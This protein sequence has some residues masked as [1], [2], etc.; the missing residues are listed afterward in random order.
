MN[1]KLN[2]IVK[3]Y[4]SLA[5]A[6]YFLCLM[7]LLT[8]QACG[9]QLNRNRIQLPEQATS[10]AIAKIENRS[11]VPRL[12]IMLRGLLIDKFNANSIDMKPTG[13]ADLVLTFVINSYN[14]TRDEYALDDTGQTY[15]F[16]FTVTGDLS[17]FDNRSRTYYL[18]GQKI[19]SSHSIITEA[20]DLTSIQTDEGREDLLDSLSSAITEKLTDNF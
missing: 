16:K 2:G 19:N 11:Y 12:D 10:I 4:I 15:D 14:L 5:N 7:C 3:K 17:I 20:T 8:F 9:F 13:Q 1:D 6:C 18:S